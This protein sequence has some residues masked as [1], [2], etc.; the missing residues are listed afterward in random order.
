MPVAPG[1][2]YSIVYRAD[3]QSFKAPARVEVIR[4]GWATGDAEM[5]VRPL[6]GGEAR[7]DPV[8]EGL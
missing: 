6:V 4:F 5:P 8:G 1:W 7:E 3:T 2:E